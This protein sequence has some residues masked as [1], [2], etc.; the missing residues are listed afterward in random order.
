MATRAQRQHADSQRHGPSAKTKKRAAAKKARKEKLATRHADEHA[1][2]KATYAI[3]THGKA[4]PS[5]K[6]TRASANRA[7][8]DTNFNLREEMTKGSPESRYRKASAK[9]GRVRGHATAG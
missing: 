6:S 4:R 9:R 8:A 7:K 2:K 1:A 5:R 3:E